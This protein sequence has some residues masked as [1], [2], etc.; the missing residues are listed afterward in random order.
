MRI[1]HTS[2]F[3]PD[4]QQIPVIGFDNEA[5]WSALLYDWEI[6]DQDP[7]EHYF[8]AG[9][10]PLTGKAEQHLNGLIEDNIVGPRVLWYPCHSRELPSWLERC[11]QLGLVGLIA[12]YIEERNAS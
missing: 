4:I 10:A 7:T 6:F 11:V 2:V 1:V 5:D 3:S 9:S 12:G 8:A